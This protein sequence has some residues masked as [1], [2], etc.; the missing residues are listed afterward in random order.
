MPQRTDEQTLEEYLTK[1]G[2]TAPRITPD[3]IDSLIVSDD[4]HV[5]EGT[6]LTVCRLTLVNGA[7]VTGESSC[8][9]PENFNEE[10][11]RKIAR[12]NAR[13]KIWT[14]AG[15]ALRDV[16]CDYSCFPGNTSLRVF[17][18][19]K[20]ITDLDEGRFTRDDRDE[21]LDNMLH[22][23]HTLRVE[24]VA[25]ITHEVNAAYCRALGDNSQPTWEDAPDWQ[26]DSA[27]NGVRFA[28]YSQ[29]A[30]PEQQHEQWLKQKTEEGWSWGP[31]KNVELK[32]HPCF[33]P[34]DALPPEQR[35]KDYLFRGVVEALRYM[36]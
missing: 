30:T 31:V 18:S 6:T 16:L 8:V 15:V 14:I 26:K 36:F 24:G 27:K 13:E 35:V 25:R 3:V 22:E 11:G 10:V 7:T 4:Y 34:Y 19:N 28:L 20:L 12:E 9:A 33:L 1:L 2:L 29:Q 17:L 21:R 32:Q 23:Y 5:F